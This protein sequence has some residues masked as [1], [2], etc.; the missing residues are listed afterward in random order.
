MSVA[1]ILTEKGSDVFTVP[2]GA[3][4]LEVA[5]SLAEKKIGV[6]VVMKDN[7]L[8]GIA[9]ERDIVR[10]IAKDSVK[11]LG[12]PISTCMTSNVVSCSPDDTIDT[13]MEKMSAGR[14]R[15]M[16]VLINGELA[17]LISIGDVVKR[18]I[19]QAEHDVEDLKR[20]I[21]S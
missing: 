12:M 6:A 19:L 2:S 10:E 3:T 9:S 5:K 13:V 15:H 8:C 17:G 4:V 21:A 14:F 7:E 1:Q 18:K 20:Y 11:A 16:P